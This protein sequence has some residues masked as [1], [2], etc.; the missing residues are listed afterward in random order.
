MTAQTREIGWSDDLSVGHRKLDAQ[1]K[2]LIRLINRF[3]SA[4]LDQAGLAGSI[5][6]LIAYAARHFNDEEKYIMRSAPELLTHQVEC[7][8]QFIETAYDFAHRFHDGEGAA[9]RATVHDFL[10]QWLIRHIREE[11]QQYNKENRG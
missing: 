3:G 1:H 7:H 10:C 2:G 11:D 4:S 6:A 8:A 9:L 5:E